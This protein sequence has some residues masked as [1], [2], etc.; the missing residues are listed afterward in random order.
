VWVDTEVRLGQEGVADAE[1]DPVLTERP[2][3]AGRE[4]E[5]ELSPVVGPLDDDLAVR[6]PERW[7]SFEVLP[8]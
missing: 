5:V 6:E 1:L 7:V 8:E 3:P 2:L 4:L